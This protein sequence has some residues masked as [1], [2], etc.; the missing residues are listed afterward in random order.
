MHITLNNDKYSNYLVLHNIKLKNKKTKL[1]KLRLLDEQNFEEVKNIE[2]NNNKMIE[3][4][5]LNKL[6]EKNIKDE[7]IDKAIIQLESK[8]YNFDA[9]LICQNN[10]NDKIAVDHLTGG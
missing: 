1:I 4:F 5:N 10:N 6:F 2:I 9:S 7:N 8:D 3:V